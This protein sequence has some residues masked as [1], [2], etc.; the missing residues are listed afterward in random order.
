MDKIR[1]AILISGRGSNMQA[2]LK[3]CQ[4]YQYP[5]VTDLVISDKA[6]APG[7]EIADS[8]DVYNTSVSHP[9]REY[10]AGMLGLMFDAMRNPPD[11]I[12]LAGFMRILDAEFVKRWHNK[13]INIHPSL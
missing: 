10:F 13:I 3:A 2:I 1:L 4:S 5:A 8:Y 11:L 7:L 9:S 12:C 6:D